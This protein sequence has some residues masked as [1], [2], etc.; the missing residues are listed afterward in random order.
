MYIQNYSIC[1]SEDDFF[2]ALVYFPI[3]GRNYNSTVIF[4]MRLKL[5]FKLECAT[6]KQTTGKNCPVNKKKY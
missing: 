1:N 2:A 4:M 6:Q 3:R 5:Y